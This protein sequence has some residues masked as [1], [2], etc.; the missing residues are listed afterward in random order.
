MKA[1]IKNT[2]KIISWTFEKFFLMQIHLRNIFTLGSILINYLL[3]YVKFFFYTWWWILK[4]LQSYVQILMCHS[5]L[6]ILS[7]DRKTY[8]GQV[9][10]NMSMIS[11][12]HHIIFTNCCS[13]QTHEIF[14]KMIFLTEVLIIVTTVNSTT[15]I[16]FFKKDIQMHTDVCKRVYWYLINCDNCISASHSSP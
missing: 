16:V 15:K 9:I 11:K 1:T 3:S 5:L 14:T 10:G 4:W 8:C 7:L 12:S 13:L 6:A 2:H